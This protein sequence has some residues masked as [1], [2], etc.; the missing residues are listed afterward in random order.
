MQLE[1]ELD[2]LRASGLAITPFASRQGQCRDRVPA[3]LLRAVLAADHRRGLALVHGL[4]AAARLPLERPAAH[5]A[6]LLRLARRARADPG[7]RRGRHHGHDRGRVAYDADQIIPSLGGG[8]RSAFKLHWS[9]NAEYCRRSRSG[10]RRHRRGEPG[11]R[12]RGMRLANGSRRCFA[13]RGAADHARPRG[14]AS[15]STIWRVQRPASASCRAFPSPESRARASASATASP[16]SRSRPTVEQVLRPAP[17]ELTAGLRAEYLRYG[18]VRRGFRSA[19]GRALQLA[20]PLGSSCRPACSPSRRCRFSSRA[21]PPNPRSR[22]TA[23]GRTSRRRADAT[24]R[25][26]S[27]A[28]CSTATCGSWHARSAAPAPMKRASRARSSTTTARAART[29]SS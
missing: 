14:R 13:E 16:S 21:R 12:Y 22:R 9:G 1:V 6:L 3:Q 2:L 7:D 18:D 5:L 11:G 27:T 20:D 19:R 10:Q 15:S 26:R 29:G 28:R 4:P 8:R 24:A 17:F 23:P 25:S